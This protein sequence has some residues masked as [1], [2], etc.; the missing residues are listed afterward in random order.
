LDNCKNLSNSFQYKPKSLK[1]EPSLKVKKKEPPGPHPL[2][3]AKK[4]QNQLEAGSVNKAELARRYGMSRARVTQIMNLLKLSPEIREEILN[5]PDK[6][7]RFF[8]ERRLRKIAGLSSP[9]KQL[10]AFINLK[11]GIK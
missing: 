6:E 2:H 7:R 4:F 11:S 1:T 9:K 8:T 3:I 10:L 5:L